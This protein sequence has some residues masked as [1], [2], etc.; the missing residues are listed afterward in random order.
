VSYRFE[1]VN[2]ALAANIGK[3][4]R[5]LDVGCGI[6]QNGAVARARGAYVVGIDSSAAALVKARQ[7]LNEVYLTDI[8]SEQVLDVL[9][10]QS[11]DLILFG[12]VLEHT[13]SPLA[14]LRR[15]STLL[16]EGGHVIISVP[17]IVA[18]TIRLQVL[19]GQFQYEPSGILDE[20]HLRFF[21]R[22]T[23]IELVNQAE[24]S[25][26]RLDLNPMLL[27]ATRDLWLA[28]LVPEGSAEDPTALTRTRLYQVYR[29]L[30]R[31]VEGLIAQAAPNLLAFQHVIVAR[32]PPR[33]GPLSLTVGML[34]RNEE[35]CVEQ[36][37]DEIRA[38]A[39]DAQILIVDSSSD[40]TPALAE[41]RGARV[42]RQLPAR[43]HAP[44]M[45]RLMYEA[46]RDSEALIYLDCDLTYPTKVIPKIRAL[47]EAGAD[48]VNTRR[49]ESR[50]QNMPLPN[51]VA[52]R[53]FAATARLIHGFPTQDVHSG[54]RG[55]RTSVIR[56]FNFDGQGDAL[57]LDTL[58][59]PARSNY[60]VIEFP[61]TYGKRSGASKLAKM[62]GTVWTY[63]RIMRA[64]KTGQRV[65]KK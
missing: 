58:L 42:V 51:F 48:V 20:T 24:L 38:V 35:A 21:T 3:P 30:I 57:P 18:W 4:R 11:F 7:V 17:N 56:A 52:N 27:R 40:R 14:V 31:P 53:V 43:G 25:L 5:V 33:N 59:L 1:E 6:G 65:G 26:L 22:A 39:P 10:G 47:L 37:I 32:K 46:A 16:Q 12:D 41:A 62:R 19:C 63:I 64:L 34:A 15:I 2:Y 45:Q 50:P 23:A 61:I 36:M 13:A 44:A 55:Y 54:M 8:E 60:R 49:T 28:H 29:R 9:S